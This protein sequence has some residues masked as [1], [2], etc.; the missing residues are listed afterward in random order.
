MEI[1][2]VLYLPSGRIFIQKTDDG[3]VIEST[4][5][6]DVSV[7][8]KL[9]I[10]VRETQNPQEIWKHIVPY[11]DKWLLTVSTQKG[12]THLQIL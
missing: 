7:D 4:E 3:Y 5:M 10:K 8:G 9:H 1:K 6:R 2:D 11:K 12:C